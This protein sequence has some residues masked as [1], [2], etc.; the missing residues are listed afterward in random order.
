L[1]MEWMARIMDARRV[2]GR[3]WFLT[4]TEAAAAGLK[5]RA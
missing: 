3:R 1:Y 2:K 4:A 5:G